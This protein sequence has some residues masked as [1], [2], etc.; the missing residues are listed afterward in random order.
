MVIDT[1]ALV[2][3]LLAE[4]EA[5]RMLDAIA[6]SHSRLVGTATVVEATAVMLGRKGESGRIALDALIGELDIEVVPVSP[7][8][9]KLAAD[10]YAEFGRGV[11]H[12][13]VLN[14]G[15]CLAYGVA[16]DLG[17]PLLFKGDDF[18]KTDVLAAAY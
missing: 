4:P 14:Y 6:E 18:A 3:I 7:G 15:D 5:A 11:G 12:P 1:S 2:A 10:A 13:G 16:V 8:A 17:E 9:G